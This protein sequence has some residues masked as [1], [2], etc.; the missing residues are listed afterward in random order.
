MTKIPVSEPACRA[1]VDFSNRSS[2]PT[3]PIIWNFLLCLI[4][5]NCIFYERI[6]RIIDQTW[7]Y[8]EFHHYLK[9]LIFNIRLYHHNMYSGQFWV[10]KTCYLS[11]PLSERRAEVVVITPSQVCTRPARRLTNCSR[12]ACKPASK[13]QRQARQKPKPSQNQAWATQPKSPRRCAKAMQQ[14]QA[15]SG[16]RS[17]H[18]R[19]NKGN[20]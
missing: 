5:I 4:V 18:T 8:I 14:T 15:N 12:T 17:K 1:Y 10:W 11:M 16:R 2:T 9:S 3:M 7:C 20:H 6:Q 13:R 19:K